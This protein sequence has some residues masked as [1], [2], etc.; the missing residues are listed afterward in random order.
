V[1][2]TRRKNEPEVEVLSGG[3]PALP[4]RGYLYCFTFSQIAEQRSRAFV[5]ASVQGPVDR[6]RG[7][8]RRS[9]A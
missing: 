3:A 2:M 8:R 5:Y 4:A 6:V 7:M 9:P 1:S